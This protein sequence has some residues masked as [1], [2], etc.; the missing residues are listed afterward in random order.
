MGICASKDDA[1]ARAAAPAA[2]AAAGGQAPPASFEDRAAATVPAEVYMLSGCRDEQTSADVSNTASF[3]LPAHVGVNGAGGACTNALLSL[4]GDGKTRDS[5]GEVLT[6][7]VDYLT[8]KK[9]T[10][11]PMLSTSRNTGMN[12]KF[13]VVGNQK[14]TKYAL[15]VGINYKG[16]SQGQL[17]GCVNDVLG[18]KKYLHSLGFQD[19]NIRCL[20]D[21]QVGDFNDFRGKR[22]DPTKRNIEAG[23]E[24][25]AG[26]AKPGDV[27]FFHYSGH[28]TS[29]KDLD[30]DEED[31]KDEALVPLDYQN[32]GMIVDDW[33]L[34]D[35]IMPLKKGVRAT[36]LMD[37]CHS[38]TILD[39]PYSFKADAAGLQKIENDPGV[40][41]TEDPGFMGKIK[42]F[43]KHV[44]PEHLKAIKKKFPEAGPVL[45]MFQKKFM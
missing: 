19:Q 42:K 18:V 11:R 34:S 22:D 24:W 37:C 45:D 17:S 25:L 14:G 6:D 44:K 23:L 8:K 29:V 12:Q 28:G 41:T 38:G 13:D 21:D 32:A 5:F 7:M 16:H 43:A 33:L 30:G 39:L 2:A 9:Y 20:V 26:V 3:Q 36:C 31:G 4:V 1:P 10:Q 35:F 15:M 40:T 27:V